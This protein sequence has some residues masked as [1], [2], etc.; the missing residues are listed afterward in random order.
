MDSAGELT[1]LCLFRRS[2]ESS[3]QRLAT[4]IRA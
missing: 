3:S 4:D 1:V 2:L